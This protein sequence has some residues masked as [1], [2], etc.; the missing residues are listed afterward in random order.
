[1]HQ[2]PPKIPL[3][4]LTNAANAGHVDSSR[5]RISYLASTTNLLYGEANGRRM[6][7]RAPQRASRFPERR[8]SIRVASASIEHVLQDTERHNVVNRQL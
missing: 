2:Q 8:V 3:L 6:D 1:M 4:R 5:A 7:A